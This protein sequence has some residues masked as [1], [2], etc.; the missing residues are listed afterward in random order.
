DTGDLVTVLRA[1]D[2]LGVTTDALEPAETAGLV[3]PTAHGLEFR[4]PLV[5]AAVIGS[6]TLAQRQRT[7]A[8]LAAALE[9]EEHADRRVWHQALATLTPDEEVAAALDAAARRSQFR[10]GHSSAASAFERA[11]ELSDTEPSRG[12]R[13]CLAAE[14]GW[15]A[16][17]IDRARSLVGRA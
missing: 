3:R 10:G 6:A 13:L 5:R 1:G 16:G 17:Q 8:A 11:A 15:E 7:H 4:H 2:S 9:G 12:Q 14:A